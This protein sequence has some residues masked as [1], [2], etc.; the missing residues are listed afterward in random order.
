MATPPDAI[1]LFLN[2]VFDLDS[3]NVTGIS[4]IVSGTTIRFD[5]LFGSSALI[6]NLAF[7]EAWKA[8]SFGSHPTR[9]DYDAFVRNLPG[10]NP[11]S[12]V[13][14]S[15]PTANALVASLSGTHLR[16]HPQH[17]KLFQ[18]AAESYQRALAGMNASS[19][20]RLLFSKLADRFGGNTNQN[21]SS[22]LISVYASLVLS[23]PYLTDLETWA[24]R[25]GCYVPP[26]SITEYYE[27]VKAAGAKLNLPKKDPITGLYLD[28]G[29]I[30]TIPLSCLELLRIPISHDGHLW[31]RDSGGSLLILGPASCPSIDDIVSHPSFKF[32]IAKGIPPRYL[33]RSLPLLL[34]SRIVVS[35][36]DR[37]DD[38][39][40]GE[41]VFVSEG[42]PE[43]DDGLDKPRVIFVSDNAPC[44]D[45]RY[46]LYKS[47]SDGLRLEVNASIVVA[48]MQ[49]P[50]PLRA[51]SANVQQAGALGGDLLYHNFLARY[52]DIRGLY[53][54]AFASVAKGAGKIGEVVLIDNRINAWSI[55][56]ILVTLDNLRTENWAVSVFC[57]N[58]NL[59]YFKKH[60]LPRVPD[61]RLE[62]LDDLNK[63]PFDIETYNALLKSPGFWNKIRSP[64]A[65]VVQDDGIL[66]RSGLEDDREILSQD[67]VGSPWIDVPDNRKMLESAGVAAGLVGNGGFSLRNV[68][69][70]QDISKEDENSPHAHATFCANMQPV[71]EDV[72]FSSA[73]NRRGRSCAREIAERF[74]F[75]EKIPEN[76]APLG[77]H[78]PWPY[79][80]PF[81]LSK[82]FDGIIDGL[83]RYSAAFN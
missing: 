82:Y 30:D 81:A 68:K 26:K 12:G 61:A 77:F 66:V 44:G 14:W 48:H 56:S 76:K 31:H 34:Y 43:N 33:H 29:S 54:R 36:N 65:L 57:S 70:M 64:L 4:E 5:A 7:H 47:A 2:D 8:A 52:L 62:V 53:D 50:C 59:E 41:L 27:R 60:L 46:W 40:P 19:A 75:E 3:T 25:G 37:F 78:K 80:N 6:T 9:L 10:S 51:A 39:K 71:P 35:S 16:I 20:K 11:S 23:D 13:A 83:T 45:G 15:E 79:N 55:A 73:V 58:A 22:C 74:A 49:K 63:T 72:F 32:R 28:L 17:V 38:R 42:I 18:A 67:F 21:D 69:A 24:S 1:S